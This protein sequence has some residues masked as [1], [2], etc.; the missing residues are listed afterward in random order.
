MKNKNQSLGKE[1]EK[2]IKVESIIK[3]MKIDI[4]GV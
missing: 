2:E 3:C 1:K 4:F